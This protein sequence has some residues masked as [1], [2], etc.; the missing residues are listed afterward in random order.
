MQMQNFKLGNDAIENSR[1]NAD[2][3]T[4]LTNY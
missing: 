2:V 3:L 1:L 4:H